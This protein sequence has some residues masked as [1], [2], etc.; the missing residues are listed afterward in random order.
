M[1]ELLQVLIVFMELL[2]AKG[3]TMTKL[4]KQVGDE[5]IEFTEAEY[6]QVQIDKIEAK[7]VADE[8]AAKQASKD[9]LLAKLGITAEEATLLLS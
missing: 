7:R 2:T 9:A 6:A 1:Q 4:F 5:V 3:M 8:V